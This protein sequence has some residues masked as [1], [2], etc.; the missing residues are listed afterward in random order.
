MHFKD[1]NEVIAYFAN[2]E[3]DHWV[4]EFKVGSNTVL[5][6]TR[7]PIIKFQKIEIEESYECRIFNSNGSR[8][9]FQLNGR[10]QWI[11]SSLGTAKKV[12][13]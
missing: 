1:D 8:G 5:E 11:I 13:N 7:Y 10:G 6:R 2:T 4:K 3:Q 9:Y 12:I